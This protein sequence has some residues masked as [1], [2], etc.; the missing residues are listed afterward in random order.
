MLENVTLFK[1]PILPLCD[2]TPVMNTREFSLI[3]ILNQLPVE[4]LSV[5]ELKFIVNSIFRL[6][7]KFGRISAQGIIVRDEQT[8]EDVSNSFF[9][10]LKLLDVHYRFVKTDIMQISSDF[11]TIY[12]KTVTVDEDYFQRTGVLPN[13]N[14]PIV[15]DKC[16]GLHV[17]E[18]FTVHLTD[19]NSSSC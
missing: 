9:T 16:G 11:T 6:G 5:S 8:N 1:P 14:L 13:P 10:D 4:K 3:G 18:S 17:L 2:F 19:N 15:V 12:D 7:Y